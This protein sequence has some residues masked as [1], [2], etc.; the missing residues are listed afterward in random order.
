VAKST[1][2]TE[3]VPSLS[4]YRAP[5]ETESG[6]ET[7]VNKPKLKSYIHGLLV[8]KA[9]AQDAR[10]DAKAEV[11]AITAE[12]DEFKEQ[13]AN[14][15]GPE[16]Q[17]QIDKLTADLEK[18]TSERDDLK[19]DKEVAELRKEVLGD[20]EAKHPKA[21]KYVKG[22]T[23]EELRESLAAVADDFGIDL[24]GG[25]N[26]GDET[27]GD[28]EPQLSTRPRSQSLL[29]LGDKE[30]GKGGEAEIDFDKAAEQIMGGRLFG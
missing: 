10:E 14:A 26:A 13:A 4:D 25:D 24:E 17:K 27:D 16:A 20:F 29:N 23:E 8:D 22:E 30:S 18:V 9:K 21:A 7:E 11:E 3:N 2:H 15:N 6:E 28:E 5:W 1:K 12:R 19:K